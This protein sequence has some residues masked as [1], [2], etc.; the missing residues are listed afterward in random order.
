ML[1]LVIALL[2]Q[3]I[4]RVEV[5]PIDFQSD[6][7]PE[8]FVHGIKQLETDG[9]DLYLTALKQPTVLQIRT[10]GEFV[11]RIGS[12]GQGPGELGYF[13]PWSVA[14]DSPGLWILPSSL[15]HANYY[16]GEGYAHQIRLQ[17]YQFRGSRMPAYSFAFNKDYVLVQAHPTTGHLAFAYR[18]D[19]AV[20][21][22]VGKILPIEPEFLKRNPALNST[23]W[24]HDGERW[25]ALFVHRPILRVFGP[26]FDLKNEF[27]L[28]GPEIEGFEETYFKNEPDPNWTFPKPHFTDFQVV[29][30]SL[31]VICEGVI[32]Q[33][34]KGSGEVKSRTYFVGNEKVKKEIGPRPIHFPLFA[35]VKN[36]IYFAI[37]GM[38]WDHDLWT[39]ELP[40][41]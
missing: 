11:R 19:G 33:V 8:T 1:I 38:P 3:E 4:Y 17:G 35:V 14:V 7:V 26:G 18:Y 6:A 5:S 29:G 32:Y 23:L 40:Y 20:H 39:A 12:A 21:K 2:S 16:E 15:K 24:R 25:Y 34:D 10:D 28:S 13:A 36:Q 41:P 37:P 22:K 9:V 30:D 27:V 31:L